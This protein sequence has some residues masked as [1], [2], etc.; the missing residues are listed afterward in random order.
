VLVTGLSG[1]K[2]QWLGRWLERLGA[3]VAGLGL[4]PLADPLGNQPDV[5]S[6]FDCQSIDIRDYHAVD[7]LVREFRPEFVFHLAAQPLVRLSYAEPLETFATNVMGTVHVL[8]AARRTESVRAVVNVTSD[9]CY[10]N[11]EWCWP[12]RE[13]EPMGGHDPYSASKGCSELVTSAY[14]Q[15]FA[16][17]VDAVQIASARAGNVIGGADWS[18]DRLIPDIVRAI[19]ADE[20]VVI[21]RPQAIRP[22]QHV[23]EALSGYLLLGAKLL[24]GDPGFASAYNFGPAANDTVCVGELA[25]RF[26]QRWGAG[27]VVEHANLEG[28]HEAQNLNLDSNEARTSLGWEAILSA[29]QR[30]DLTVDW[31]QRWRHNPSQYWQLIDEQIETFEER[32]QTWM[33]RKRYS[34]PASQA[35]SVLPSHA[36]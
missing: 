23:L 5:A 12:Y 2:G 29:E 14:R 24:S 20:P 34:S 9:K 31:Y 17:G 7:A 30:I 18:A 21:R 6:T 19:V 32:W 22:W 10:E 25:R 1:F 16:S 33:A 13:S 27:R 35:S 15:S 11:Q 36:A 4:P 28:P 3:T 8:E 26:V